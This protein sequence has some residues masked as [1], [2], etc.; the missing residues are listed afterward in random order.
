MEKKIQD[1][2]L[3]SLLS[4]C[5]NKDHPYPFFKIKN[6]VSLPLIQ[7]L[8]V[9]D[10]VILK[11]SDSEDVWEKPEL[12]KERLFKITGLS[13]SGGCKINLILHTEARISSQLKDKNGL[14]QISGTTSVDTSRMLYS[15][16][17]KALVNK[18]DFTISPTG[19]IQQI[20][21]E[22]LDA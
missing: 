8:K 13:K 21:K 11:Q 18:V 2:E 12:L 10:I 3:V 4:I 20:S 7:V 5:K 22:N 15:N 17:I 14:F 16:Q 9:G 1:F 19:V 6:G